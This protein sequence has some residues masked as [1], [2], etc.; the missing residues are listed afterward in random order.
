MKMQSEMKKLTAA[1]IKEIA[2]YGFITFAIECEAGLVLHFNSER[3]ELIS[4]CKA[5]YLEMEY[6]RIAMA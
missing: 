2:R 1:Q 6:D 4:R 5:A 3:N